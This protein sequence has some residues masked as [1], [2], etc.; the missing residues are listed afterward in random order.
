M[1]HAHIASLSM[2][3]PLAHMCACDK[4]MLLCSAY[5][6]LAVPVAYVRADGYLA[7]YVIRLKKAI[8][9]FLVF[10]SNEALHELHELQG[11]DAHS[12]RSH[13]AWAIDHPLSCHSTS[14]KLWE[15]GEGVCCSAIEYT[16]YARK[17]LAARL[18]VPRGKH[19]ERK[20]GKNC[21]K[22]VGERLHVPWQV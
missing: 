18:H 9:F 13:Q 10:L 15:A 22:N 8:L 1:A 19:C 4:S 11:K 5:V 21:N 16:R 6:L 12:V 20:L 14:W 7:L 2:Y 3:G 17:S